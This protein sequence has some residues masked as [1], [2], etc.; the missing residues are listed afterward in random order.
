M[1]GVLFGM[2]ILIYVLMKAFHTGMVENDLNYILFYILTPS[3]IN[4][5]CVL[6]ARFA[7][8]G[9]CTVQRKSQALIFCILCICLVTATMMTERYSIISLLNDSAVLSCS[10]CILMICSC[11]RKVSDCFSIFRSNWFL[12]LKSS[13]VFL[14]LFLTIESTNGL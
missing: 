1:T 13:I 12:Q 4:V 11:L 7:V 5:G 14:T 6:A 8:L 2:E 9:E 10:A 3:L